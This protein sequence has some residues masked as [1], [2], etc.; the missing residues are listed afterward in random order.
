MIGPG[1]GRR[2]EEARSR[3]EG[4]ETRSRAWGAGR[5]V[6]GRDERV[7]RAVERGREQKAV[8]KRTHKGEV[9]VKRKKERKIWR[10]GGS[11][12]KIVNVK[13]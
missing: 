5:G 10:G 7:R 6:S 11:T 2:R 12:Q 8:G 1:N 4:R 13:I 9:A 3:K